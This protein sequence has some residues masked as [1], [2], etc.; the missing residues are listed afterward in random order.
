MRRL[1]VLM[2]LSCVA[3]AATAQVT[4]TRGTNFSIDTASDGRLAIDLLGRIWEL[5]AS[6]GDARAVT[7]GKLRAGHPRWAPDTSAIV[8]QASNGNQEQLWLYSFADDSLQNIS[9]G[10]YFDHQPTWH[11]AGDR[12]TFASDRRDTGFDLWELDVATGLTWRIS[13][14]E[15]DESAPAWSSDGRD[16]VFVHRHAERWSLVLRRHG[17]PDRVLETSSTPLMSP[18]WRPDGS[19]I[20]FMQQGEAGLA[21]NM[22][23]LSEPLLIRPLITDE[24]FFVAPITWKDRHQM[25]YP[26]NGLIRTRLFNSWTSSTIPF[27]ASVIREEK[28]QRVA[29]PQRQLPVTGAPAGRLVIRTARLFDG[30]GGG[31]R[32]GLDIVIDGSRI[33]AVEEPRDRPGSIL[34]DMGDL[35][36]LPGYI[37]GRASLPADAS[38]SLGPILLAFGLT[39]VITD[40]AQAVELNELWSGKDTPGP[41]VLAGDWQLDIDFVSTATLGDDS[42]T[43]SPRGIRYED[44]QISQGGGAATILSGIADSR[45]R[46][47]PELLSSRQ[48]ALVKGYPTAI[49][50]F[51][52][53]PRL[54][55]RSSAIVVGSEPNGFA[56]GIALH[57]ELRALHEAG[58]KQEFVL[59]S[60]GINAATALGLGLQAGRIA[61]GS[62]ADLVLVD[63]DPLSNIDDTL[64]VVGVVRN[65]RFFS[66]IGLIERAA[67]RG[68]VE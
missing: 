47:L 65:G 28:P 1:F 27:R 39:T 15:G 35:T 34:V 54:D 32:E 49:R 36:T 46:G 48:A 64:N 26:A 9:D 17:Q 23:I 30:V 40:H 68:S 44:A 6:G 19:L 60:A 56:P 33:S 3:G 13:N 52:G 14:L 21:I 38:P 29:A 57:A 4:L 41:R 10:Q 58:L 31:Y 2:A 11:P 45:T 12:I 24:D 20:T 61:P 37:D 16:L 25:L 42:L 7:D 66:T 53:I 22:A 62:T 43:T 18:A 51:I 63:G 8:F 50:R 5:P 55:S 59:R 67:Q